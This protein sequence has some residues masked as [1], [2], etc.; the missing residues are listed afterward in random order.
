[1][2]PQNPG[3]PPPLANYRPMNE[4]TNEHGAPAFPPRATPPG[5]R[6]KAEPP[7]RRRGGFLRGLGYLFLF[8][9]LIAG[10]GAAYLTLNPPSDLIRQTIAEQVKAK[11]GRDL[12]VAGP[13]AFTFY[14]GVGVSLRDVSLSGPPGSNTKLITMEALELNIKTM[15]LLNRQ[16]EV[17]R[18]IL[19]KPVFDLR[20]GKDGKKNWNFA[21]IAEPVRYAQAGEPQAPANDAGEAAQAQSATPLPGK[22]AQIRHLELDDVRIENGTF[23]YTDERTGRV[24]EVS[25]TNANVALASLNGALTANGDLVWQ[26]SK[27]D[28]DGKFSP[29]RSALE[30]K[31]GR[32]EFK[33]SN[34]LVDATYDGALLIKDGADLEGKISAKSASARNL[35]KWFGTALPAAPGFGPMSLTGAVKTNGSVTSISGATFGLDGAT[36]NGN[37]TVTTGGVRPQ[38]AANLKFSEIDLNKYLSAGSQIAPN[39]PA[40]A[41]AAKPTPGGAAGPGQSGND[42]IEQLLEQGKGSKVYGA[43]QRAGWSSDQINLALLGVADVDA[44]LQ[45]ARLLWRDIKI[46]QSALTVALKNRVLKTVFD[47]IQ[48]YDGRGKGF[49]T[50]DTAGKVPNIGGNFAL[51]GLSAQSFLKDTAN[52][53]WLS[54]KAKVG[55]QLASTGA[56]ELQLVENLNGKA[57]V[58]FANGA[59][60]G[61]N[62]PGAIRGISQGNLSGLKKTPTEKT[63]FSELSASFNIQNGVAQNQD[64]QLV[65]PL[66]RVTGAGAIQ[67]PPR[68]LDYTVKPKLVAS[69]EGQQGAQGL[70]GLEIPVRVVGPW[71]KPSYQPDINGVLKNPNAIVDQAK[72]IGKQFKGKNAGEIVNDLLGKKSGDGTTGATNAAK[73]LLNKFLKPQ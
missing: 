12:V 61:F 72:E 17:R 2:A 27:I 71:D 30:E 38:V 36:A 15:P 1:M 51:D 22:L 55:V 39:A 68:T 7:K 33:A 34:A 11:T 47:D 67:L 60:V 50:V 64:L 16:V 66:L 37:V 21:E 73:D 40:A 3:P 25:N 35:A 31:P 63:D 44:K 54:G 46:G 29:V 28:F 62:L 49:L 4:R 43:T 69:L 41:P 20:V 52:T 13:A 70:T 56:S 32:L 9:L 65:S 48:L 23:R 10:A 57:D 18:L 5:Q 53:D 26:G 24:Q 59:I 14:P 6:R 58:S 42:Q 19:Q 8:L 45:T